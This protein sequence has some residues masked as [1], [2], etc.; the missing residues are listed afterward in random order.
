MKRESL[1]IGD[2]AQYDGECSRV[3][4][5]SSDGETRVVIETRNHIRI[6]E[7]FIQDLD[8]IPLTAEILE[9]NGFEKSER[10]EVWRIIRDDYELRVAPWRVAVIFLEDGADKE[11]YSLP[12]PKYVHEY[13]RALRCFGLFDLANN[14]KI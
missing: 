1:M 6:C 13:Q 9:K 11:E 5:V 4:K 7:C 12:R 2:W 10:Y 3:D 14:I 8:P